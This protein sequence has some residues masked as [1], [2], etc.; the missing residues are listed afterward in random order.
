MGLIDRQYLARPY[1]GS[2]RMTAWLA[3]QCHLI[4]RK[5]VQRLMRLLGL[6]AIARRRLGWP[7][8]LPHQRMFPSHRALPH[9]ICSCCLIALCPNPSSF[10]CFLI[11]AACCCGPCGVVGDAPASSKR[12]GKSTRL[13]ESWGNQAQ[14]ASRRP[15]GHSLQR[16][17][18]FGACLWFIVNR[19]VTIFRR[20]F[21]AQARIIR[22]RHRALLR[23]SQSQAPPLR[24]RRPVAAQLLAAIL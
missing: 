19:Y 6:V 17:C 8:V 5:R 14:Y 24:S 15:L 1:Y 10:S 12:S 11:S 18:E 23:R 2:R 9:Q 20:R 3:T 13:W 16:R 22:L 7:P 21:P 4:N